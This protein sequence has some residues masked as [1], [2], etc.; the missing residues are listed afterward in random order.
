M[1]PLP[2]K[3]ARI[4]IFAGLC[5]LYACIHLD[6]QIL[7]ILAESVKSD[8]RIS[9]AALGALTG[10]AFSIVY[11]LLGLYFGRLADVA[12]RLALVRTGAW[13]WSLPSKGFLA[14]AIPAL[15]IAL[16]IASPGQS[17]ISGFTAFR[18][19]TRGRRT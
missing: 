3:A 6:R 7:G 11:A 17:R 12:D 5:W 4:G 13:V 8:L 10:S 9:D 15:K 19:A 14:P 1:Q 2:G 16:S 18:Q